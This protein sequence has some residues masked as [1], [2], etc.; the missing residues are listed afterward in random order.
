MASLGIVI[1]NFNK[2][3]YLYN[4]INSLYTTN[5]DQFDYEVVVVDNASID[6]SVAM[7]KRDF[8]DVTLLINETNIGGAGGFDRG[9]QYSIER[10]FDFVLL[11]DNDVV[12][13]SSTIPNLHQ[14]LVNSPDVGVVGA[15][16][17]MMDNPNVLQEMGSYIDFDTHFSI[18]TPFKA[19]PDD[20]RLPAFIDCDYVPACCLMTTAE[21][22]KTV[23]GFDV[24]HFIYWDDMDWC[25]RVKKKGYKIHAIREA[26]VLHKMSSVDRQSTF[27]SYYFQRNRLLFFLKHLQETKLDAF[28]DNSIDWLSNVVFF[29]DHKNDHQVAH[30]ILGAIEDLDSFRLKRQDSRITQ[31]NP[32]K[33]DP[34]N[35]YDTLFVHNLSDQQALHAVSTFLEKLNLVEFNSGTASEIKG[36][37]TCHLMIVDHLT[38]ATP[39]TQYLPSYYIDRYLNMCAAEALETFKARYDYFKKLF[40]ETWGAIYREK[41]QRVYTRLRSESK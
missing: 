25:I 38:T 30:S 12:L 6:N 34:L 17:C 31:R 16:I 21:V 24:D 19:H 15:K 28:L 9:I 36:S 23:G 10:Q 40:A 37:N 13:D 18:D 14:Y 33:S 3:D 39:Q 11:L 26:R 27:T 29:A 22:L 2:S 7:V 5:F 20:I 32:L 1:C 8:P 35:E 4:C 41:L